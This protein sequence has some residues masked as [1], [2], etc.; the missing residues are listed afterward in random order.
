MPYEYGYSSK[1]DPELLRRARN[2]PGIGQSIDAGL[3][4]LT[5]GLQPLSSASKETFKH[6]ATAT[7]AT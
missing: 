7:L 1:I 4:S 3:K 2:G 6:D 5:S